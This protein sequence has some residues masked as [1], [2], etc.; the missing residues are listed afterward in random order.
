MNPTRIASS[1]LNA[2]KYII[3]LLIA[4][5]FAAS[6]PFLFGFINVSAPEPLASARTDPVS[7]FKPT[8]LCSYFP[9]PITASHMWQTHISQI[10]T[11]SKNPLIP[12]L[13]TEEQ[14]AK[15]HNI[16]SQILS[17]SRM[18]RAVRHMPTSPRQHAS[19]K[20]VVQILQKRMHDPK[21]NPPL[22]IAV[23]GGSVTIG[24]GCYGK[25][26]QN[27]NCAWP[28]RLQLLINQ[29]VNMDLVKVYNLGIGGTSS[30]VGTNMVKYWMYPDDLAKVGPD[31]IIN[32]Y[33][34]N[35]S[36]PP[37]D[38]K[39]DPKADLVTVVMDNARNALQNFVR[40]ALNSK[41]CDVPPLMVH[42]DD[43]LGPQQDVLLGEMSYN[44]AM[45]QLA[46]WYD[47]VAISYSDVVRDLAWL[48]GDTTFYNPTDA[49]YGHWAHQTIAWSVGFAS[50][51]LLSNYCDD[52]YTL[53]LHS[54]PSN[55]DEMSNKVE[56]RKNHL[57]LPPPLT[58][59]L[60]LKNAKMRFSVALESAQKLHAGMNCSSTNS[61]VEDKNPCIVS[62][63]ASPGGYQTNQIN[64]FMK[65]HSQL[66]R[67]RIDG[68]QAESQMSEGWG[69]KVGWA[70][71]KAG[72]TF[73]L[74]FNEVAK[75]VNVV[76]IFFLRSYGDKWKDSLAKFTISRGGANLNTD[77]GS[78][79]DGNVVSVDEIAGVSEDPH[80]L[81]LS[82]E[83]N[84]SQTIR[85]GETMNIK[86]DLISGSTF[87]VMGMMICT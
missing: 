25:G 35:D 53:R 13:L 81:T 48:E 87:K 3:C 84:L 73:T 70:A 83:L 74:Q 24:R 9:T 33:S 10:H 16:L 19:V 15:M 79:D 4:A 52:E 42:V 78:G 55:I 80:S 8:E 45:V 14:D 22:R 7:P 54:T 62:W 71:N 56:A 50:L 41:R 12:D 36:L 49:H 72:A 57:F 69:N 51:E 64:N 75:D 23:F 86:V 20:H 40:T 26:M 68:W 30:V 21:N 59:E 77:E 28:M 11:A 29:F 76:T 37:W 61:N 60:I 47:T 63:I 44:T 58:R 65:K 31:V 34:T 46:K 1:S 66:S 27:Y 6:Q 17:P 43:Y 39:D 5:L 67:V 18:R 85:R 32:S 38:L 82:Q 2:R